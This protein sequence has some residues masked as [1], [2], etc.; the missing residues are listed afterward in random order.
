VLY[1]GGIRLAELL[2]LRLGD[3]SRHDGTIKVTGKGRKDRIVPIG[4]NAMKAL[5]AYLG[6]RLSLV[7]AGRGQSADVVFLTDRGQPLYARMVQRLVRTRIREVSE[8]ARQSPHVL[9]H[10]VATHLLNRGA[11][12]RAVKELLGHASLSTTQIYTHVSAA[13]LKRVYH[14]AHPKA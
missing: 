11:D 6:Q 2:A 10:T 7:S 12:L 9:R 14:Q 1:G 5:D 8:I 3:I 13:Q 4:R